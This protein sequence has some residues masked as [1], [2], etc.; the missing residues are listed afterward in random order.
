MGGTRAGSGPLECEVVPLCHCS[1]PARGSLLPRAPSTEGTLH[2]PLWVFWSGVCSTLTRDRHF[3]SQGLQVCHACNIHDSTVGLG[4]TPS[5]HVQVR[6][7]SQLPP[8]T[9]LEKDKV[10]IQKSVI[11]NLGSSPA[12]RLVKHPTQCTQPSRKS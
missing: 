3:I 5:T 1:P 2:F 8:N 10:R 11:P 7:V 12:Q 4:M 6:N 9:C